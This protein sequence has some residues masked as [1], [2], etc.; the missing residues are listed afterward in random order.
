MQ[1]KKSILIPMALLLSAAIF[2]SCSKKTLDSVEQKPVLI[3]ET[4]KTVTLSGY[5][6]EKITLKKKPQ[7]VIL[8]T[9][10]FLDLW[11]F[12]GG[13]A[14]ARVEG[15]INVPSQAKSIEIVGTIGNPNLEKIMSLQPDLVIINRNKVCQTKIIPFLDS[16]G[17]QHLSLTYNNYNDFLFISDLFMRINDRHNNIIKI[18]K[19]RNEI[20]SIIKKCP[21]K[22]NPLC[23]ISFATSN[24]ISAELPCGDTGLILEMLRGRNIARISPVKKGTCV[25][26]SIEK[27]TE[28]NPDFM[29]IKMMGKQ[30]KA[31]NRINEYFKSNSSLNGIKAVKQNRMY[32]LPREFFVYKPNSRYPEAFRYLAGILYPDIF[33]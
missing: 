2:N 7:R 23:L 27:I 13:K 12:A 9:N 6:G 18:K 3:G 20:K 31:Q 21:E 17:I 19:I 5:S 24:S 8:L 16:A 25:E 22:K 33:K 26:L 14:I 29:F 10:S 15:N 28:L 11:Y 1:L 4:G 30:D 32:T